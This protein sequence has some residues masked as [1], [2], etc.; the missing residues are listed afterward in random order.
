MSTGSRPRRL[1]AALCTAVGLAVASAV[2]EAQCSVCRSLLAAP[3]AESIA[4][5]LRAAIWV[6]LAAP[7]GAL[8]VVALAV[9]KSRQRIEALRRGRG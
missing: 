4:A 3:E 1:A 7:V 6:L 2:P 9:I 8:A 5:A